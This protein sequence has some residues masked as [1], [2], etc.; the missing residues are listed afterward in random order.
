MKV[1]LIMN[2][3]ECQ[4]VEAEFNSIEWSIYKRSLYRFI[5][6]KNNSQE[7]IRIAVDMYDTQSLIL[8]VREVN[9]KS[10]IKK[11]K[12]LSEEYPN[13]FDLVVVTVLTILFVGIYIVYRRL[14]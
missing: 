4:R 14:T 9:M 3:G 7:D 10:L 5:R 6:N 11:I 13:H 8:D 2:S 12:S 1:K